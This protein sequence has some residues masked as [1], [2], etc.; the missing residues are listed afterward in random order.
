MNKIKNSIKKW[1]F[2]IIILLLVGIVYIGQ[3]L[4]STDTASSTTTTT[5]TATVEKGTIVSSV[6]T[7]GT[8]ETANYLSVTTSVN[9]IVK[10]V[11]VKEGDNVTKGQK[12]M[13]VTLNADGEESLSSAW[14]SYLG[15]KNSLAKAKSDLIT[16]KSSLIRAEEAFDTE[17]ENNTYQSHDERT[18]YTLA[19][20]DYLVAQNSYEEQLSSI[21]QAEAS[22]QKAW[23]SYQSQ[24][25]TIVAPDSGTIANILIVEGMDISNSLSEKTSLAVASI[26]KEGTPIVS[27]S[28]NELDINKIKVGQQV[29]IELNAVKGETFNGE[30]VGIDKIGSA[31][32]GVTT[33]TVIVKFTKDNQQVLPNMGVDA[34]I[35]VEERHDIVYVNTGAI[36]TKEETTTVTKIIDGKEQVTEVV[37]GIS[38]TKN[39]E[40]VSGVNEGDQVLVKAL[41]TSG[42]TEKQSGTS[43]GFGG[44][45][46][47]R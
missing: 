41:S 44:G 47:L 43:T 35:I 20:N 15:A 31:S 9:G 14:A 45:G 37:T 11:F 18:A 12:I 25:P 1:K 6:E 21:K 34:E 4:L 33:Y 30:V 22:L 3:N 8:V 29:N 36:S 2:L 19:E 46:L 23:L 24:S 27:L 32:N 13:E 7:S 28:V 5:T 10:K 42:F 17:K 26:K 38:N 16:K 40:I 39:T